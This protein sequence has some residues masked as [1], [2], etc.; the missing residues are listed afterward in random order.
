[1]MSR[2]PFSKLREM[3]TTAAMELVHYE[4]QNS[5]YLCIGCVEKVV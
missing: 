2:W 3:A 4:D 1:M 5:N